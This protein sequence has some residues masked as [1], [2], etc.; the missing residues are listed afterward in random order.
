MLISPFHQSVNIFMTTYEK[1]GN[2][3]PIYDKSWGIWGV[4]LFPTPSLIFPQLR[5]QIAIINDKF[6]FTPQV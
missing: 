1:L 5:Y 2:F 4:T 3:T 6:Q